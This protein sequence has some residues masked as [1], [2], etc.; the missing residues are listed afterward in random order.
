MDGTVRDT[1]LQWIHN[2]V[3]D[4]FI[5]NAATATQTFIQLRW[6]LDLVLD[7]FVG[8]SIFSRVFAHGVAQSSLEMRDA[9]LLRW[10]QCVAREDEN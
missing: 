10:C 8:K 9:C 2:M 3:L 5:D 4:L 6:I 7:M 1:A